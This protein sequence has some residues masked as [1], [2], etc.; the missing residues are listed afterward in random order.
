MYTEEKSYTVELSGSCPPPCLSL[1]QPTH[2]RHPENGQDP[3]RFGNLVKKLEASLLQKFAKQEVSSLLAPFCRLADDYRFWQHTLD[4]LAVMGGKDFFRVYRLQQS[5]P[6]LA[7]VADSFHKKPL[8]RI[9][10][11]LDRFHVLGLSRQ[12]IR[13]FEGNRHVLDEI[14]LNETLGSLQSEAAGAAALS[15]KHLTVASYGGVGVGQRSMRHGHAEKSSQAGAEADR[16]FRAVD[17]EILERF[18]K[19]SGLPL[20]LAALP[21]HHRRF[22]EISANPCLIKESIDVYPDSLASL[23]ELSER[24]WRILEP[25]Y[26]RRLERVAEK[27]RAA[28]AVGLGEAEVAAVV[29]AVVEGRVSLLLLEAHR[30]IPGRIDPLTGEISSGTLSHPEIDD[31]LDDLGELAMTKGVQVMIVPSESMPTG[32]GVAAVFRY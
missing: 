20:L 26:Q 14:E 30:Q 24:A 12:K 17:R 11:S 19:P 31:L 28:T 21:E 15:D 23:G 29:R 8:I 2:R 18:S 4:G 32:T 3:I 5:V 10:Q 1:Y 22:H 27:F 6:E 13:F 25:V 9:L 16:F 7:I